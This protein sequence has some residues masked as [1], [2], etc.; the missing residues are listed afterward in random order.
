MSETKHTSAKTALKTWMEQN[1]ITPAVFARA[2]GYSYNHAYQLLRGQARVSEAVVA[3]LL[4][5]FGQQ[6]ATEVATALR[7]ESS[8]AHPVSD[9]VES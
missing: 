4:L 3:R 7:Q 6:I 2:T 9:P 8:L 1:K 5:G